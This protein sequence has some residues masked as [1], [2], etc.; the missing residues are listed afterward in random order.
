MTIVYAVGL[1]HHTTGVP[2]H[3]VR[4]AAPAAARQH[5]PPGRRHERRA[6]PRQ[7]P[8]QHRPRDLVGHPARVPR[9]R[10]RPGQKT[11]DDYV[12]QSASKK[13]RPNSLNFFGTNYR[14]FMVSLLKAW[15]GDAATKENEFAFDYLPKPASNSSWLSIFD[16]ALRGQDGGRHA[17]RDDRDQHR[18]RLQPGAAGAVEPQVARASWTRFQTTSSEF[19]TRAGHGP[20]A[21]S[22]PRCSCCRPRTGSR[23]TA[24]SPTAAAGRSGRSRCCRPRATPA[25]TTGSWPSSSQRVKELY[26]QQGGKFPDPIMALDDAVQGSRASRSWTRS[27]RRSTA[28]T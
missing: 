10:R 14:K 18:A 11:V 8:G 19:W 27:P 2:A 12:A 21:R 26:Q 9:S 6:R 3:P 25:T 1:T 17:V 7:H 24:R 13:L 23:R 5:G 28:R 20:E 22:R 4:R 16:Q 15:Y